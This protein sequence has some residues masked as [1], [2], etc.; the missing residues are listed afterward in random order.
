MAALIYAAKAPDC[1]YEIIL[2]ASN[3]PQAEG[4]KIAA[5]EGIATF[6]QSHI[7]LTREAF[8]AVIDAELALHG[9]D[10]VALAGYMR[11]LSPAFVG[12]WAGRIVNIHPSLLPKYQGVDTYRRAIDA[13]DS[14][15]GCSVHEVIADVDAG[16]VLG[17]TSVVI[18]P[19]D[20]AE[21]LAERVRIAEHQLYPRILAEFVTRETRPEAVLDHIRGL[22]LSLPAAQEKLSHGSPGFYVEGGKFFAYYSTNHHND[23]IAGLLVKASGLEEQAMLIEQAPDRYYRPAYLGPSGWIGIRMDTG[24]TDW[25]HV[26]EWLRKSWALSAPKRLQAT[27]SVSDEF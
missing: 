9:P 18:L 25:D 24:E 16:A 12:K 22:A 13:G 21:T 3:N 20:T 26:A 2:V 17:Q 4:L 8:D 23:G 5:S 15:A 7:G 6:S 11:I 27:V 1:P 14:V 10:S 19:G